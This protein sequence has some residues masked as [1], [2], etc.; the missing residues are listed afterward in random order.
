[1]ILLKL[2]AFKLIYALVT[3]FV[4]TEAVLQ[5]SVRYDVGIRLNPIFLYN[6]YCD[7]EYW[8]INSARSDFDDTGLE[9]HPLLSFKATE[10]Q[11][12]PVK[13]ETQNSIFNFGSS[14]TGHKIFQKIVPSN[15]NWKNFSVSSYGLDQ[16]Y[17]S[18]EISKTQFPNSTIVIG[19][20]LED[21]DRSIFSFQRI[22]KNSI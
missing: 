22:P 17:T 20:L 12:S 15:K 8:E 13:N 3:A 10:E 1:M 11:A 2:K 14:F 18:Y 4:I 21:L 7:Q 9:Y 19:F 6:P 5:V 16:I